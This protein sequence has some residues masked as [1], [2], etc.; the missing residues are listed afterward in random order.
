MDDNYI[1]PETQNG[2]RKGYHGMNNPFILRTA[3]DVALAEGKTLH[4]VFPDLTNTFPSM[5]HA[6][7]WSMMYKKGVAGPLFDWLHMLYDGMSYV[8]RMGSAFSAPFRSTVGILAGDSGSPGFWNFFASDLVFV[9]HPEDISIGGR[10]VMNI[11]QA[12]D[13]AMFSGPLGLQ[14]HLDVYGPWA[15]RKGLLVNIP[16]TKAMAFGKLPSTLPVFT[17]LGRPI[18]WTNEHKYL[19]VTFTSSRAD[20]F[21]Q[22][23]TEKENLPPREGV[24]IYKSRIDPH[25]TFGAEVAVDVASSGPHLLENVQVAYLRRLLS[26]QK[27]SIRVTVFTETGILPLSYCRIMFALRYLRRILHLGEHRIPV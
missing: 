2:F 9:P 24:L 17:I 23:Y 18:E 27:R 15:S 25:L 26:I 10:R 12:D 22:H 13:G 16:K 14:A 6:S 8:V 19:G 4:V 7:L 11:E 1:L 20:I 5:D 3:I 21:S